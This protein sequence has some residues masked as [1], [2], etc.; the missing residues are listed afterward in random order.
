MRIIMLNLYQ[1]KPQFQAALR[2]T[3]QKL[4]ARGVT[5]N[6]I[7]LLAAGV[8]ILIGGF[9]T[10]FATSAWLFWLLPIWLFVRMA[11]NAL[12]GMLA[13][14]F[15]QES[16]LGGYLNEVGDIVAD[17]ALYLPFAFVLGGFQMGLFI[18]LA[19][20]TEV[21]GLLGK[22]HGFNGRRYDG[23]MGKPERAALFGIL[24]IWYALA[25]SLNAWASLLVWL[26]IIAMCVTCWLR[27][28]NGLRASS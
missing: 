16:A 10:I 5:A 12:D 17:A 4:A 22:V 2:P 23:F 21:F 24:A 11:L 3:A 7:T 25:G 8:S 6:Q 9:L 14:E 20:L 26:A 27:L 15:M 18:W 28:Q 19:A 1:I 13:R